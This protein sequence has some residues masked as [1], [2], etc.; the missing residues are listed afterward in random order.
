MDRPQAEL[1]GTTPAVVHFPVTIPRTAAF[2]RLNRR[3]WFSF[4]SAKV[5]L[6]AALPRIELVWMPYYRVPVRYTSKHGPGTVEIA[7]E[8][9]GGE[10]R[11]IA[12]AQLLPDPPAEGAVFP[13]RLSGDEATVIAR[14][15]AIRIVMIQRG[16]SKPV[17]EGADAPTLLR[18][19]FWVYYYERRRGMIDIKT[20]NAATG[21]KGGVRT[22]R[23]VLDALLE[24]A[25]RT[26]PEI[27][28]A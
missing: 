21:E 1:V 20:L 18:C 27:S 6:S 12:D 24:Q 28:P 13:P 22:K 10:A 5:E 8:A 14:R 15:E 9:H 7:V 3:G 17:I 16:R 26:I 23:A 25:R 11:L 19:P 4:R 2:A